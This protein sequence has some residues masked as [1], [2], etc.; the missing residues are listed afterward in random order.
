MIDR[1]ELI[2]TV[3]PCSLMCYTC[4]GYCNGAIAKLSHKLIKQLDGI[5]DFYRKN[6]PDKVEGYKKLEHELTHYACA[7]CNG[8]RSSEHNGCS[9]KDVLFLSVQRVM[10]LISVVS[11]SH[12]RVIR[13]NL[14]LTAQ[15]TI[16]GSTVMSRYRAMVLNCIMK[17][18]IVNLTI[19]RIKNSIE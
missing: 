10:A 1:S 16:N 5:E 4:S 3:A 7:K 11:V 8:C 9:I 18:T 2:K 13:S 6:I 12:S 14:Y 17:T 19:A 15:Y